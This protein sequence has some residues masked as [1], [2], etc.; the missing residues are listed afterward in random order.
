MSSCLMKNIINVSLITLALFATGLYASTEP[1]PAEERKFDRIADVSRGDLVEL[2]GQVARIADEDEFILQDES[3]RVRIY[4]G[5]KN[6]LPVERGDTVIVE[7]RADDS[8]LGFRPEIYARF[9]E[10]ENGERIELR[11]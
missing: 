3:G 9:L 2:R 1:A 4:I 5:W 7:G 10:L 8:I 11:R 6:D